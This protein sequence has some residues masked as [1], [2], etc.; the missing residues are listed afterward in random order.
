[1]L[2][3]APQPGSFELPLAPRL[4]DL[5]V[6]AGGLTDTATHHYTGF[7]QRQDRQIELRVQDALLYRDVNAN[8]LLERGDF[9]TIKQVP[10]L[11]VVVQ[12]KVRKPGS[13]P[14]PPG[15]GVLEAIVQAGGLSAAV[16]Q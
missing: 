16:G 9:V 2:H 11:N 6:A 10:L 5:I 12:G 3:R 14:V 1:E 7:I 8:L 15:A 13:V 4:V